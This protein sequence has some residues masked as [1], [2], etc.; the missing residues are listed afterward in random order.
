MRLYGSN[1]T[2]PFKVAATFGTS[3]GKFKEG[4][5]PFFAYFG[6]QNTISY[7]MRSISQNITL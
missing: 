4:A 1:I 3:L 7:I 5:T 6:I 2:V